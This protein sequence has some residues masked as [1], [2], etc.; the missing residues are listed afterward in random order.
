M[1]RQQASKVFQGDEADVLKQLKH[2]QTQMENLV[3]SIHPQ[4]DN[5]EEDSVSE[6]DVRQMLKL[7][8]ERE[9]IFG[10]ELFADPAWDIFLELYRVHLAQTRI[11]ITALC[12]AAAVPATTAL[13]WIV[14]LEDELWIAKQADPFD[15]RRTF[16]SLT[17][18]G[19]Q[20]IRN[21]FSRAK[22][23]IV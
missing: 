18:K 22:R 6:R 10:R 2:L 20:A 9:E 1:S 4:E 3:S 13:R 23:T 19:L 14:K 8:Q 11:S 16:V 21:F 7:R 17:P 5:V 12:S 15:G